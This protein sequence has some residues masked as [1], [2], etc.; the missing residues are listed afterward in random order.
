[1]AIEKLYTVQEVAEILQVH[2][3]TVFRYMQADNKNQL[4]AFKVGRAWRIK[5]SE[6]NR[7][8]NNQQTNTESGEDA[9]AATEKTEA[10][11]TTAKRRRKAKK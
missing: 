1:M 3:R 4:Q 5:E 2:E 7:Y 6:L 10:T 11:E 8:I 9:A